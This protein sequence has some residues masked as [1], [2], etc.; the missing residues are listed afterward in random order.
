[1]G[2]NQVLSAC[3]LSVFTEKFM[4]KHFFLVFFY[5]ISLVAFENPKAELVDWK[6]LCLSLQPSPLINSYMPRSIQVEETE[7]AP[8]VSF[9]SE[10][11][12]DHLTAFLKQA[13]EREQQYS[14]LPR[15]PSFETSIENPKLY[16]L[17]S[18]HCRIA[19][20]T[21]AVLGVDQFVHT[22]IQKT[23]QAIQQ[24]FMPKRAL[25]LNSVFVLEDILQHPDNYKDF[26][27][28]ASIPIAASNQCY[29]VIERFLAT[30]PSL[31]SAKPI[32]E[33]V[34]KLPALS[35]S[36]HAR[37]Y[38]VLA[39]YLQARPLHPQ[40]SDHYD[41][42]YHALAFPQALALLLKHGG[43]PHWHHMGA[44]LLYSAR[45]NLESAKLLLQHGAMVDWISMWGDTALEQTIKKF[46]IKYL[47]FIQ[48]LLEHDARREP[49]IKESN[50]K[51]TQLRELRE[52]LSQCTEPIPDNDT[53]SCI[54]QIHAYMSLL[55]VLQTT[56][57][58]VSTQ[59][60]G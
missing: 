8:I 15:A 57:T 22:T 52:Q 48:L 21:A 1:M 19:I 34:R 56:S 59:S 53:E 6:S 5:I 7:I 49:A 23:Y 47:P 38:H 45:E 37:H 44:S 39:L 41:I 60:K 54:Q 17:F 3:L 14:D 32:A 11:D 36:A 35:A 46:E 58:L 51:L 29:D 40:E 12:E 16:N 27:I 26:N 42:L 2:K 28:E 25:E 10:Q 50:L 18:L 9:V 20:H 30:E 33:L 43:T 31:E 13:Y 24:Q 55:E 4:Y